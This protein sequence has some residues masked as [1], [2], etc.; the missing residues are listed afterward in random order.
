MN[1][2]KLH[3]TLIELQEQIIH[4]LKEK[5][6][7]SQAVTDI[8]END[9]IDPEDLSHQTESAELKLL[10]E[11]QLKKAEADLNLLN[12]I[13]FTGKETVSPGALV[14]TEKFN[15]LIG[16]AIVPFDFEGM[17]IVGVSSDSPIYP[18]MKG[19]KAGESFSFSGNNYTIIEIL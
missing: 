14:K 13:N 17:H 1:K 12:T 15:F 18:E 3:S 9:I 19:K 6:S 5:M 16:H 4:D 7:A 11:Q 10:F 2:E 8:D